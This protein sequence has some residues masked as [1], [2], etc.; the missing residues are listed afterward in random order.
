MHSRLTGL[1][2]Q[3]DTGNA[4]LGLFSELRSVKLEVILGFEATA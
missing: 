2:V 1:A 4:Q 3:N